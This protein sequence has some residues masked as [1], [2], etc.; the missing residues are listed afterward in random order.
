MTGRYRP[1]G[2]GTVMI[3][4][5]ILLPLSWPIFAVSWLFGRKGI[6]EVM[7]RAPGWVE[8]AVTMVALVLNYHLIEYVKQ[9]WS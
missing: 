8:V 6:K 4:M 9:F 1:P 2:Y 5:I 3:L 7:D